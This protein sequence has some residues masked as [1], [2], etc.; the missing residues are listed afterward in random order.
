[1]GR[2]SN[3]L[4][5]NQM[6]VIN[7]EFITSRSECII[8]VRSSSQVLEE[9]VSLGMTQNSPLTDYEQSAPGHYPSEK[10]ATI[11]LQPSSLVR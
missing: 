10:G 4:P 6:I 3:W 2:E 9:G 7:A 8:V 11:T 1:M 5:Q